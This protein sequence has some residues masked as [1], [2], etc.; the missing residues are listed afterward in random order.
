MTEMKYPKKIKKLK[1][2]IKVKE[3]EEIIQTEI[4]KN[5]EKNMTETK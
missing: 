5:I 1:E 2:Q 4:M 3:T